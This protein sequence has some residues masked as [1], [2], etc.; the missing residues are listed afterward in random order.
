[1]EYHKVLLA[2]PITLADFDQPCLCDQTILL[3]PALVRSVAGV[4]D[5]LLVDR[6]GKNIFRCPATK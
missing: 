5:G 4:L 2:Y 6:H 1:M 3:I